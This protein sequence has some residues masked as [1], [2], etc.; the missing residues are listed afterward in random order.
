MPSSA[1]VVAPVQDRVSDAHR[2]T[3]VLTRCPPLS[4]GAAAREPGA[5]ML[6][7]DEAVAFGSP[8]LSLHPRF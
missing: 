3:H 7:R 8:A 1:P 5:Q 6:V 4:P 2:A